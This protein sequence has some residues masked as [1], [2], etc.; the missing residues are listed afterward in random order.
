VAPA[1]VTL[2]TSATDNEAPGR[3]KS[4]P[5]IVSFPANAS[6][7]TTIRARNERPTRVARSPTA[8]APP[9]RIRGSVKGPAR[10]QIRGED[11][12]DSPGT[13]AERGPGWHADRLERA[14]SNGRRRRP[15]GRRLPP[16]GRRAV[17]GHPHLWPVREGPGVPGGL[18]GPVAEDAGR[19]P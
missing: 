5:G 12:R 10:S 16:P 1:T 4:S 9:L 2:A 11:E 18:R 8:I 6:Q 13:G 7:G 14:R 19:A 17:P 3:A 15:A